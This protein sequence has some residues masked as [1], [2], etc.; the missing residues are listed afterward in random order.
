MISTSS[1]SMCMLVSSAASDVAP[2][3]ALSPSHT[4]HSRLSASHSSRVMT[5]RNHRGVQSARFSSEGEPGV[6]KLLCSQ[7]MARVPFG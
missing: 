6:W 1:H 7:S 2:L 4:T 3:T 5:Y